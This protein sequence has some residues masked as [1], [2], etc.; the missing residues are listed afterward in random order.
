MHF[1]SATVLSFALAAAPAPSPS[2]LGR[3]DL[4]PALVLPAPPAQGSDQARRELRELRDVDATR[5]SAAVTAARSDGETKNATIFREV[6][7]PR[8]DLA[9]LPAT[10]RLLAI[11]RAT[12]KDVAD[13][14]KA[15]FLRNRPWI[16]Y[17]KLRSCS[18]NDD[19]RSSYPSGHTTMGYAMAGVLAR[20]VPAK[21]D[22]ILTRA[23]SY[24]ESRIVCEV[25]FRSDVTAG[26]ALGLLVAER[27]MAKSDFIA[28]FRA[29]KAELVRAGIATP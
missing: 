16:V 18:R 20:L 23:A 27:L 11:V 9:H 8:F 24:G 3:A 6:L 5:P 10:A 21:A 2:M 25:H 14:G 29:A 1:L 7:G 15:E 4:D 26:E 12:E 17:P 22:R 13:R 19:P 28:A